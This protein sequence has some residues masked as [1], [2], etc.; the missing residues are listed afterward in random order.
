MK[1]SFKTRETGA[2]GAWTHDPR[3][4]DTYAQA[5]KAAPKGKDLRVIKR[6]EEA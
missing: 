3:R 1:F 6:H 5:K 2:K 4:F